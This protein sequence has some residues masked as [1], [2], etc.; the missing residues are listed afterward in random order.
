M[1]RARSSADHE[2]RG[3]LLQVHREVAPPLP[4]RR[5]VL[6]PG[7]PDATPQSVHNRF[8]A[9]TDDSVTGEGL[10]EFAVATRAESGLSDHGRTAFPI[11][12]SA[13]RPKRLR[14]SDSFRE[15]HR[16]PPY[17][18]LH[19]ALLTPGLNHHS[20]GDEHGDVIF[21]QDHGND[22]GREDLWEGSSGSEEFVE[23][24]DDEFDVVE[25][26][27]S[28]E[29]QRA[30]RDRRVRPSWMC[31]RFLRGP[32]R[33]ALRFALLEI[34]ASQGDQM[35]SSRGWKLL[36]LLPRLLLF[37]PPR[38]GNISK[39]KLSQR[40]Q[41]FVEKRAAKAESGCPNG[42][43]R[44]L[45]PC[46]RDGTSEPF[47]TTARGFTARATRSN[48]SQAWGRIPPLFHTW[49]FPECNRM[50]T[51]PTLAGVVKM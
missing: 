13:N 25:A 38:G 42:V 46:S 14:W 1:H 22:S 36:M 37:R 32:F 43:P 41:D 51:C 5:V 33:S 8:A 28:A 35:R 49:V 11:Q 23:P 9:L 34:I 48:A 44:T 16:P 7:S 39:Q 24:T 30:L 29:T 4:G 3:V 19:R 21:E 2:G 50:R 31:D 20:S 18:R 47:H 26:R 15:I 10:E 12:V 40:F 45:I 6:V 17:P 27:I